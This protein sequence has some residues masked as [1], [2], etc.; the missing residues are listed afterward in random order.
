[1]TGERT[2]WMER[3]SRHGVHMRLCDILDYNR[4]IEVPCANGLVVGCGDKSA[5]FVNESNGIDR[6]QMLIILLGDLA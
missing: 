4:D 1:M 5:I 2:G 3:N 6:S